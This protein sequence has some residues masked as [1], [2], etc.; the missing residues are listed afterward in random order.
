MPGS[1]ARR[2]LALA[3]TAVDPAARFRI[4]QYIPYLERAGWHVSLRTNRPA[5]PWQSPVRNPALRAVHRR[6]GVWRR[7]VNRLRDLRSAADFDAVFLNRDV[8]ESDI[9]YERYLLR[10]NPRLIFDFDDAIFLDGKEAHAAWVCRRAAW[11]TAGNADLADFARRF[12]DRVTVLPTVIDTDAYAQAGV[13]PAGGPFRVGWCGSDSS[14]RQ[15]LYPHLD[16]LARL[17]RRLGFEFVIMT[18]PR[19]RLPETQLR[20]T[21]EEWSEDKETRLWSFFDAGIMPLTSDEYQRYKCGCKLLQYMASGLPSVASPVGINVPLI[22]KGRGGFLA[23]T[24]DEWFAAL[25]RLM[26]DARTCREMGAAG[27]DYVVKE[28]SLRAWLPVLLGLL[29]RVAGLS[30]PGPARV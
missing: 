3:H 1:E 27:R 7:R 22:E 4:G 5:R 24:E 13:R 16:L 8:L 25:S 17:Q 21:F 14:I 10:R 15:T 12:T 28:Y 30:A 29:D 9:R 11:V 20:W 19:P 2:L 26:S 18:R 23:A 6:L